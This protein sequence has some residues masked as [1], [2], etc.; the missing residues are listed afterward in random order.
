MQDPPPTPKL[1]LVLGGGG[2][3]GLAHLGVLEVLEEEDL[4]IERIVG[5]SAGAIIGSMYARSPVAAPLI[6]RVLEFL[7]SSAFR[8]L[9]L[10][11]EL[12][13]RNAGA[14]RPS[15]LDRILHGLKR[16][17]AMELLF[18][19]PS[20]FS[21][22]ILRR[23]VGGLVGDGHID[24]TVIPLFITALD[25]IEGEEVLLRDGDLRSA[26]VA[27]S[28]V[29]GFFPP[30][31]REGKLLS[32]AGLINNMPVQIAR[33]LGGE[34]VVGVSL[35][36]SVERIEE[37]PTGI[38]VIFRSEEIGTKLFNDRRKK[39][40]D[41]VIE[42]ALGGLYWL[43]FRDPAAVIEAGAAAAREKVAEIRERLGGGSRGEQERAGESRGEPA[44]AED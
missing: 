4:P 15:L 24:E 28:S 19:R 9:N 14:P 21:G 38:D 34:H 35:N 27:S 10:K 30:V 12:E 13:G 11:F 18:R 31:E 37:F 33:D 20:I 5:T 40:A 26:V 29:P 3:R 1:T 2:V 23:L 6:A 25:L 32:D 36:A 43:E 41:V 17:L 7:S 22:D 8:R 16:Q 39:E 42:P 44:D